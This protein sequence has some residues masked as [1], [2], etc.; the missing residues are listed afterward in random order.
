MA[1][2]NKK[3]FSEEQ[4]WIIEQKLENKSYDD[5]CHNYKFS[6]KLSKDAIKTC[7]KRSS[8]SLRW[9]KGTTVGRIPTLSEVD[10]DALKTYIIDNAIDGEFI[11]VEETIEEAERLRKERIKKARNFLIFIDCYKIAEEILLFSH[12]QDIERDWVYHHIN[13]LKAELNT[14]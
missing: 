10:I 14:P 4:S 1:Y 7:L 8:L 5:I 3:Y 9:D 13:E 2:L 6:D 11:E 12:S